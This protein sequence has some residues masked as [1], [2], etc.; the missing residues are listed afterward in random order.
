ML[1]TP[2]MPATSGSSVFDW[3]FS[4]ENSEWQ[5]WTQIVPKMAIA[6][7]AQFADIIVPTKDS[8]RYTFL[9]NLAVHHG[10]PF[11]MVGPTGVRLL[12]TESCVPLVCISSTGPLCLALQLVWEE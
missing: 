9:L 10:H 12:S 5:L 1:N 6:A 2:M 3:M 8:A 4:K 7:G 11:L